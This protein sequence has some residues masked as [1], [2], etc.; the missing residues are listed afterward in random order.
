MC[1]TRIVRDFGVR[2]NRG[3][4]VCI[5]VPESVI[6]MPPKIISANFPNPPTTLSQGNYKLHHINHNSRD[7]S[8]CINQ[9]DSGNSHT[10]LRSPSS[11]SPH[12]NP[13][14]HSSTP[15]P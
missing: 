9:F 13:P 2:Q 12:D 6:Q 8:H 14:L 1:C 15:S 11:S 3:F 7:L 10:I 5:L 4:G